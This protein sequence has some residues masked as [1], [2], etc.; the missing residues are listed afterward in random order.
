M[1]HYEAEQGAISIEDNA[2]TIEDTYGD[3]DEEDGQ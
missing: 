3:T 1:M 2:D